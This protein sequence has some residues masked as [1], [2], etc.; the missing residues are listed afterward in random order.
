MRILG[1]DL[2][3]FTGYATSDTDAGTFDL[4]PRSHESNG[5]RLV[6]FRASMR[7]LIRLSNPDMIAFENAAYQPGG[8]GA[9]VVYGELLGV[10]KVLCHDAGIDY[11]GYS[12]ATVKKLAT[13]KGNANKEA[14][15]AAARAKWPDLQIVDD[16][17]ADAL[18]IRECAMR[19]YG[20]ANYE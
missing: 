5:M 1:L 10:L 8:N 16:N 2:G 18:W 9:A 12:A 14:M 4:G 3:T 7:D 11:H 17:M 20:G 6:K 13:G 15:V 19:E